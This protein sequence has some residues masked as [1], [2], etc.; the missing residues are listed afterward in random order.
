MPQAME[1]QSFI[2]AANRSNLFEVVV[3]FLI[4]RYW[5]QS[6]VAATILIFCQN[7]QRDIQEWCIYRCRG[8]LAMCAK[9]RAVIRACDDMLACECSR[10]AVGK[11]REATE[12]KNIAYMLQTLRWH[13]LLHSVANLLKMMQHAVAKCFIR[14]KHNT[15]LWN[16]QV[17]P[18]KVVTFF[19]ECESWSHTSLFVWDWNCWARRIASDFTRFYLI[20]KCVTRRIWLDLCLMSRQT[21]NIRQRFGAKRQVPL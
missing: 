16:T 21:L 13:R 10:I 9:P 15:T 14:C 19:E 20:V 17:I 11:A 4:G 3:T 2:G 18:Q 12:H 6:V 1:G 8:L 7:L 5:E